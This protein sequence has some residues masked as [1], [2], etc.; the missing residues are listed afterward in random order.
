MINRTKILNLVL[1][2]ICCAG[3]ANAEQSGSTIEI[4]AHRFA[5]TPG[6]INVKKGETV[7]LKLVSDDVPHSLLIKDLG[8]NQ[9]IVKG[10]PTVVTITPQKIGD[11]HGQCGRFCGSG[12]GK[13]AIV[14]HVTGN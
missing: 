4:H 5:F 6:E 14:V 10:K 13:M 1:L 3:V 7:K 2:C 8:I 9:T 11:F 12:H